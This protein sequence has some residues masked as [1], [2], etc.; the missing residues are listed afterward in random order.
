MASIQLLGICGSLRKA[1]TNQGLLRAASQCLP[2][3]VQ[4]QFADLSEIPF[5]NA[6]HPAKPPAVQRVLDQIDA[7][8][9]FLLASPEYNYSIAPALKNILDWASREPDNQL[10]NG[11]TAAILG[12]GGGMGTSRSQ[13]HLRQVCVCLNLHVLNKPEVFVNAFTGHFNEQGDLIDDAM[14]SQ[15]QAQV[16]AL[17]EFTRRMKG[18]AA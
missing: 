12:A 13:Y 3:G 16:A 18:F 14:Q 1:S 10:L 9:G 2:S 8:D 7:A 11:K 6:D 17:V 5:Y 4:M 15:V